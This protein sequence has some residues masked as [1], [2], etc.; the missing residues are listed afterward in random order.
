MRIAIVGSGALGG[1]Y[2][3]MLARR[4]FEVHF[5][6][7]R[8]YESVRRNGLQVKSILG[9]FHLEK[10]NCYDRIEDIPT[11]DLVFIGLKTTENRCY[12]ELLG[13]LM[14][15]H[16]VALTAQNGLG[17]EERLA[18]LFGK[19]YV[20]GG[21]AFLCSNRLDDGT[22]HHLDY[23]HMHI[24]NY[25]RKP[26]LFLEQFGQ[27]LRESG[28]ACEVVEDLALS[29]WKKLIWN[30]PFNGLTTLW[31]KMVN[32][33][34]AEE[35]LRRAGYELMKEI[36]QG[37]GGYDLI[38]EDAFLDQMMDYTDQMK[39]YATSMQLDAQ[40]GRALEIESIFGE[41]LRRG[42]AKGVPMPK[43]QELYRGLKQNFRTE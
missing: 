4:G 38:I 34:M 31:D 14:G 33:V 42:Q 32:E 35:S 28:V 23:G 5:L 2:G 9:D 41:P 10:V 19:E 20:A 17:N 21:L 29:R 40:A 16:A 8:F 1:F 26:D 39:P 30:V 43:L 24:G 13:P 25:D 22:I 3:A 18:A 12:Q 37:A 27:M 6:M 7:R 36:Q 11:V 15:S